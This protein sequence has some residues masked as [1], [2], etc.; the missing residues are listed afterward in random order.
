MP[1]RASIDTLH[2][3]PDGFS[4]DGYRTYK[5]DLQAINQDL[6]TLISTGLSIPEMPADAFK[7]W[8]ST[9]GSLNRQLSQEVLRVAVVGAI[10]SGKSTFLN[11]LLKGDFLRRGAGNVTS[12]VTR[13]RKGPSRKATLVFKPWYEINREITEALTLLPAVNPDQDREVIDI[14]TKRLRENIGSAL[15]GLPRNQLIKGGRRNLSTVLLTCYLNGYERVKAL[16]ASESQTLEFNNKQFFE[17]WDFVGDDSLAVYLRDIQLFVDS[18][19]LDIDTEFADCQGSDSSNPMHLA[20]I[21]DYLHLSHLVIYLISSRTGLREADFK[22]LNIIRKM[23]IIDNVLFIVNCDISEHDSLADLEAV[24]AKV[25]DELHLIVADP[26]IYVCSALFN[27]FEDAGDA[28][29]EKDRLRLAQWKNQSEIAE[30]SNQESNRFQADLI[31]QLKRKHYRLLLKNQIERHG[32]ILSGMDNWIR[33]NQELFSKDEKETGKII[34]GIQR[35]QKRMNQ[36]E[37]MIETTAAGAVPKLKNTLSTDSDRFFDAR[38]GK[39]VGCVVDFIRDYQIEY[40]NYEESL[41]NSGFFNTVYLVF[42]EFKQALNET[43]TG[44][45][46]PEIVQFVH[47]E[48]RK[49]EKYFKAVFEPYESI[50]DDALAD[51]REVVRGAAIAKAIPEDFRRVEFPSLDSLKQVSGLKLPP[52]LA[53][54]RYSAKIKSE[55]FMKLSAFTFIK[56]MRRISKKKD[57]PANATQLKALQSSVKRMKQLTKRSIV[58]QCKDYRENLKFKYLFTLVELVSRKLTETLLE[59]FRLYGN[60][61]M[62]MIEKIGRHQSDKQQAVKIIQEMASMAIVTQ[63]K[64]GELRERVK[65]LDA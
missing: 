49:I 41:L 30:L 63:T 19:A 27:L 45:V 12:I 42:Q 47:Q 20:M 44:T 64:I 52:L 11:A 33:L 48:E 15:E 16:L 62:E 39:C 9:C 23:G 28:L 1:G 58:Y 2:V 26:R 18:P 32:A 37:T 17:H 65:Q 40:N 7:D 54:L 29:P 3:H 57:Q 53:F 31:H 4:M 13:V 5:D 46:Y 25:R 21:Q 34:E 50:I 8:Q 6:K 59:R 56:F 60:D 61:T 35:Q 55:A 24:V 10:K 22:F 43:M 38:S 14:R 51:L 36:I